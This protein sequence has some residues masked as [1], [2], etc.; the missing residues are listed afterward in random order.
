VDFA[1]GRTFV[2]RFDEPVNTQDLTRTL[3]DAFGGE[4]PQVKT[5]GP[6][7]QVKVIT[8][9]LIN[10]PGEDVGE[11]VDL[12]LYE[13]CKNLLPAGTTEE[14]FLDEYRLDSQLV[15][16]TVASDIV[17]GAIFA[18]LFALIVIFLYIFIRY[19][20]WSFGISGIAALAHDT[21]IPFSLEIDQAF[22][23]A[24]LT[25]I[26]YSINDTVIVFDRVREFTGL[27]RK[28]DRKDIMNQAVNS[29]LGRTLNTAGTTLV[30]LLSIFIFGGPSIRGFVFALLVGVV[31]GTYSS[32]FV[33][34]SVVYDIHRWRQKRDSKK[35]K[36]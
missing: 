18:V 23:A 2:F 5:F 8:E 3:T 17:R 35:L 7:N 13:G 16:P 15:G 33:S 10:E 11:R 36:A 31:V 29:T 20:N 9:Y 12:A 21:I 24:I 25:I 14:V 30:V 34:T 6:T 32:I 4:Q 22:I 19:S 28:R 1:G 27:Y 26:G